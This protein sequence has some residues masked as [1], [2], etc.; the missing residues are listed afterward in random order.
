M[1]HIDSDTHHFLAESEA[2]EFGVLDVVVASYQFTIN[3]YPV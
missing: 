3:L 1:E 2:P